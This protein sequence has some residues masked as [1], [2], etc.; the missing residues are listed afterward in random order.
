MKWVLVQNIPIDYQLA[1]LGD[2]DGRT[3]TFDSKQ[4]AKDFIE[5][6]GEETAEIMIIPETEIIEHNKGGTNDSNNSS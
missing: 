3:L 1:I 5:E 4:K 2:E 6:I